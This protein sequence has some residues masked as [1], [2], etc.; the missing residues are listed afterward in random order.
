MKAR[1]PWFGTDI[2]A[3]Y[4]PSSYKLIIHRVYYTKCHKNYYCSTMFMQP[5]LRLDLLS[6]PEY[7]L[8]GGATWVRFTS[9]KPKISPTRKK[10]L[11]MLLAM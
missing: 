5:H 2:L 9:Q 3:T 10:K 4:V 1:H 8:R 6:K 11:R 7:G